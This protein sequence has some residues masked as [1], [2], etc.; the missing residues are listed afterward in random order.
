M[1]T[2]L[3]IKVSQD[4]ID[5]EIMTRAAL[6]KFQYRSQNNSYPLQRRIIVKR[7]N[8]LNQDL[9]CLIINREKTQLISLRRKW[10][11]ASRIKIAPVN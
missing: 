3:L 11:S 8:G 2:I 4:L 9:S 5:L 10:M 7:L 1:T 6:S